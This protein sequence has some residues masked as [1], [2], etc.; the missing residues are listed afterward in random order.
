MEK[1]NYRFKTEEEFI[2]QYGQC[3]RF[4]IRAGWNDDMDQFFGLKYT[5]DYSYIEQGSYGTQGDWSISAE[6]LTPASKEDME[7]AEVLEK[8]REVARQE[9][10]KKKA[11]Y[12]VNH[13]EGYIEILANFGVY[14]SIAAYFYCAPTNNCQLAS[15]GN[16]QTILDAFSNDEEL[17]E[18]LK[19]MS[20]LTN[21]GKQLHFI[22]VH[23]KYYDRLKKICYTEPVKYTSTNGSNM[24]YA[25]CRA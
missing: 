10:E 20:E 6:M 2:A 18:E 9:R 11:K 5:G 24:C 14:K 21:Y 15:I 13:K 25:I 17:K 4:S 16:F 19:I 22:D 1:I 8:Q 12:K 3:W 23:Q 7:R